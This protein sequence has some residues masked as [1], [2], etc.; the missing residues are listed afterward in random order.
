MSRIANE[1]AEQ[2]NCARDKHISPYAA[3]C[4]ICSLEDTEKGIRERD[5]VGRARHPADLGEQR[6]YGSPAKTLAL[7]LELIKILIKL[8]VR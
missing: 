1:N 7:S 2:G 3:V 6:M 4:K 8:W 5:Q